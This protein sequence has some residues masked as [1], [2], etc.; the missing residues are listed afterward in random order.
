MKKSKC[1]QGFWSLKIN[2]LFTYHD[3]K[4]YKLKGGVSLAD[5]GHLFDYSTCK[6]NKAIG[7]EWSSEEVWVRGVTSVTSDFNVTE[8]KESYSLGEGN[9]PFQ[10]T[11][12]S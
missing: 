8:N 6:V 12:H 9:A 10:N 11:N 3:E 1:F 4:E 7:F 2:I 5:K